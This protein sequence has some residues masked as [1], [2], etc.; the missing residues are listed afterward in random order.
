MTENKKISFLGAVLI[1]INVVVGSAFLLGAPGI[2][3]K[4]GFA[5]PLLWIGCALLLLPL[6]LIFSK[7]AFKYPEAG[8]IY[9]YSQ[10]ELGRFWGYVSAWA[11]F[12]GTAAGNAIVLRCFAQY[13]YQLAWVGQPLGLIGI[14]QLIL[15]ISLILIFT[16]LSLCN[17][18]FFERAQMLFSGL[19]M[20]PF[21]VLVIGVVAL[22]A[23]T[24][25]TLATVF[26]SSS[27]LSAMPVVL[28]AYIGI[29]CCSAIIDKIENS[30][31]RGFKVI[32]ASFGLIVAVYAIAQL[33]I[34]GMF[35][36][37]TANPFLEVLPRLM[38]NQ[39]LAGFGNQLIYTAILISFLGG[40]YGLFYINNW[41]LHALAQQRCVAGYSLWQR[42]NKHQVPWVAVLFQAAMLLVMLIVTSSG[43]LLIAMSDLG[44]LLAYFLTAVAYVRARP[45][46]LGITGVVSASVL[47]AFLLQDVHGLGWMMTLPFWWIFLIGLVM[48]RRKTTA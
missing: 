16:G 22:F 20:I 6:V 34:V 41:N 18:Q 37:S 19:K 46:I 15:E 25:I 10:H 42:L 1:N 48:Y 17:V 12:V 47:G 26:T 5:A 11:Y 38:S 43:D 23:P 44:V 36:Q 45:G 32:L 13:L 35:G 40:F 33:F 31:Q 2:S 4:A 27:M 3:Q 28:F 24:N 39:A 21:L 29:E 9:A 14:S 30:R 7:F 8:G